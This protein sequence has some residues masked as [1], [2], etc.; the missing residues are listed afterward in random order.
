M[1][2]LYTRY[3]Q[4]K[5]IDPNLPSFADWKLDIGLR[6]Y[7]KARFENKR[8]KK[9]A[10]GPVCPIYNSGIDF[11]ANEQ[12]IFVTTIFQILLSNRK[13]KNKPG[14]YGGN[15]ISRTIESLQLILH[16]AGCGW[17]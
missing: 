16:K 4:I 14:T 15:I 1:D 11:T 7:E 8:T 5:V 3:K 10:G 13:T 6:E 17:E 9:N 2:E 12:N